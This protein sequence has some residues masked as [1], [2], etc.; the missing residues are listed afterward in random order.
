M[1]VQDVHLHPL[2]RQAH[3]FIR[4]KGLTTGKRP[5]ILGLATPIET[6]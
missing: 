5:G 6:G 1:A 2:R 3:R 4:M